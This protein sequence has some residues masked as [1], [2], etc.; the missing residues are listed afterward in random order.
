M[1]SLADD[2]ANNFPGVLRACTCSTNCWPRVVNDREIPSS[3]LQ[4]DSKMKGE[5]YF[6]TKQQKK[7]YAYILESQ[8]SMYPF[9][10]FI[11]LSSHCFCYQFVLFFFSLPLYLPKCPSLM[12]KSPSQSHRMNELINKK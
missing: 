6:S 9:L 12:Q 11:N 2:N 8:I 1:W 10:L 5:T 4:I 7:R 3:G